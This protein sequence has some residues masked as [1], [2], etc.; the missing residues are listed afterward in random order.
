M[1]SVSEKITH[2]YFTNSRWL[3]FIKN[4]EKKKN[5]NTAIQAMPLNRKTIYFKYMAYTNQYGT[6]KFW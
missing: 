3:Y 1:N 4:V 2:L 5:N 6:Q